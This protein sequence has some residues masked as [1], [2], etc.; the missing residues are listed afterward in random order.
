MDQSKIKIP[1]NW[2]WSGGHLPL[3]LDA[4]VTYSR[5]FD[6]DPFMV[7]AVIH[8][9]SNGVACRTRFEDHWFEEKNLQTPKER[10]FHFP[11]AYAA[12]CGISRITEYV[13][14]ATSWGYFQVM[15]STARRHGYQGH[16]PYLCD[17]PT[18]F[19]YGM[20]VLKEFS[21]RY[22]GNIWDTVAAYNRGRVEYV[23]GQYGVYVNQKHVDKFRLAYEQIKKAN[24]L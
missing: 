3:L 14:Q 12:E 4:I 20:K 10:N 24:S 2:L 5:G 21:D 7:A 19:T 23:N 18:N 17:H 1:S 9:E 15:G 6:L 11:I 16:L 8:I 13:H 22:K